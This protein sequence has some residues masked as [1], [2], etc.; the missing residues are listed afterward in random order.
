M[1]WAINFIE[2][3]PPISS[4]VKCGHSAVPDLHGGRG[5]PNAGTG[6]CWPM[7][8]AIGYTGHP[9]RRR[10]ANA[11]D[12]SE[13]T[14]AHS[15]PVRS[16]FFPFHRYISAQDMSEHI[17]AHPCPV[18]SFTLPLDLMQTLRMWASTDVLIPILC[19]PSFSPLVITRAP[20]T[21]AGTSV[22]APILCARLL[23]PSRSHANT[24][25][26]SEHTCARSRPAH[27]FPSRR[28]MSAQ[29]MSGHICAR[30]MCIYLCSPTYC[31]E[32]VY[33]LHVNKIDLC[34]LSLCVFLMKL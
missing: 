10:Y 9:P 32:F 25:D 11:Q 14:C 28:Y 31:N 33:L 6:H 21:W 7:T 30:S 1:S 20:R 3:S 24:Q 8:R 23:F 5:L 12:V 27:S 15:R 2:S 18:H 4:C 29:D 26:M 22:P 13:H 19:V 16:F 17:C 34:S